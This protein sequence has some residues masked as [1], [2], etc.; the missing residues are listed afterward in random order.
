MDTLV[1]YSVN[2]ALE[3][4]MLLVLNILLV[5]CIWQRKVFT[6]TVP[7]ISLIGFIIMAIV[8]QIAT[9]GM[10]LYDVPAKHGLMPIRIVFILD[11]LFGYGITVAFYQYVEALVKD[12]YKNIGITYKPKNSMKIAII[13]WGI[14]SGLAYSALLFVPAILRLENDEVIF[15]IPAYVLLQ[16]MT[17]FA[18]VCTAVSI[19]KN[20]KVLDRNE[21][22]LS[23]IFLGLI[24]V[25]IIVDEL[26]GLCISY[27]LMSLFT[28]I[29]YV[30]IDLHKGLL[31]ERQQKEITQWQTQIMLSQMQPHFLYNILTTISSMCEM[32]NA[33]QARDVV[34]KF[35]D[36]FRTNLDSLGKEKTISFKKELEH[37]E[38]Y[39]WLE[40]IRF[41]DN[42]NI[43]YNIGP[44]D[45]VLPSLAVQPI[46]ENA[47][48]HGILPKEDG[49]IITIS[50][51][52]NEN[53]YLITVEDDGIGFDI[54][55]EPH[56]N[57]SHVGL[58]NV[59]KRLEVICNGY[60]EINSKKDKG[61]VVTLHIPKGE[62]L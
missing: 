44:V 25:F 12:G 58:E 49:G 38:T 30:R 23:I 61:T 59:S 8:E 42:L 32:Q 11:Y 62:Q 20:K 4:S 17:K 45:F 41:E 54:N 29:I 56:D 26:C 36:Y 39:L 51:D 3:A 10:A 14:V 35:A 28:F 57:R 31:L 55:E 2:I 21:A 53:E 33:T 37:I 15:S 22:T 27:V 6:T 40:K 46:V 9:N 52:E 5:T 1:Q 13:L 47:V 18:I 48:K 50:T 34:N 43:C 24:S 19:I 7:L 60:Y 16:F